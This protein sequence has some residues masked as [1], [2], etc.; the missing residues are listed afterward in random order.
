MPRK[1]ERAAGTADILNEH[2]LNGLNGLKYLLADWSNLN[3]CNPCNPW[4]FH[5]RRCLGSTKG[6]AGTADVIY[7]HGL[8]GL[9][10]LN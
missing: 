5:L 1:H 8:N 6:R 9:N 4:F 2:G 10:R 3:P 7:E